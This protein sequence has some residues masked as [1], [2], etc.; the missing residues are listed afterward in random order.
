[1]YVKVRFLLYFE[2][3][4]TIQRIPIFDLIGLQDIDATVMASH[5]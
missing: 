2:N 4:H 1:M 3:T 5:H